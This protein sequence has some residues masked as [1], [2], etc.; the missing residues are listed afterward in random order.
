MSGEDLVEHML[1]VAAGKPLPER[2]TK[3]PLLPY[4]GSAIESRVYAEDPIRNFLPSI[5]PLITYKEPVTYASK[6]GTV[7]IDTGVYEGGVISMH[8]DPMISKLCTHAQTRSQAISLMENALDQYVVQGLGN[9][10]TFLRSVYRNKNFRAGNYCTKFIP[11]EYPTGFHGVELTPQETNEFIA[12]A[13]A[14]D[15]ARNEYKYET[16]AQLSAMISN[17]DSLEKTVVVV[18]NGTKGDAYEVKL[19]VDGNYRAH[20]TPLDAHNKHA[21]AVSCHIVSS[22]PREIIFLFL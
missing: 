11:E 4:N 15:D 21:G 10:I 9:N 1:W 16:N 6:E 22:H 2:L 18:L 20:I 19:S 13:A 17:V 8:Y 5:G 3:N 12:I 14:I 7:R